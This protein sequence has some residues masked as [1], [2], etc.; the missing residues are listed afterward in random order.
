[1]DKNRITEL[2][3]QLKN[4]QK[5][6][7]EQYLA[8]PDTH[9]MLHG[10]SQ[11]VDTVLLALWADLNMPETA[12]LI[13]VGGYGRGE[14][15]P[16]SDVDLLI[17]LPTAADEALQGKIEQLVGM[18]WDIGLEVGHS[19]RTL[20]ECLD[21]ARSDITVQTA[22]LEARCLCGCEKLFDDFEAQLC[23]EIDGPSFYK[24]KKLE[25]QERYT[26]FNDTP[27]SLEPNSKESP[28]GLRDL[29]V[30]LWISQATGYGK[31]WK[32]LEKHGFITHDETL[33]IQRCERHLQHLRIR[34]HLLTKRREDRL[35]FDY[36]HSLAE[37]LK[38]EATKAR[39]ASEVLMQDYYK[40]A[41]LVTQLN[42]ILLQNMGAE[43]FPQRELSIRP[44]NKRFQA[45][46][47][48]LD[49]T[50][51][52][53]FESTP[54]AIL[55]SFW[56][57]Q[58]NP[59]LKGMTARTLR[60]LWRGRDLINA[61]FRKS[62]ENRAMFLRLFQSKRGLVHEFRRMNQYSI[63]G[64][65]IPA[66]GKIVG[67]MQHDL[68]HVYTV[69]QHILMVMRNL[70]RFSMEEFAHEY[71]LCSQLIN[72]LPRHWVLYIA[73]LFHDIAKGRG[74]DHSQLGMEDAREFCEHHQLNAEDTELVVWLVGSHLCM[75]AVAQKED[76]SDPDVI[77]HFAERVGSVRKLTALYLLTV[78]DIR[79]TSP[80]V[81][82]A[83]KGKLL[84]D[85]YHLALR[86]LE[87]SQNPD[88]ATSKEPTGVIQERQAEALRLLRFFALADAV[89]E[90]LWKQLDTVYFLRHS[91]DEIAWHTRA[92]HYRV[93]NPEPIVK[94]RLNAAGGVQVMVFTADQPDLFARLVGFFARAG[95]NIVDAKIH[96]TRHG[97]ALDSFELLD[98]NGEPC[99]REFIPFIEHE[100]AIA[101]KE[102][103]PVQQPADGRLSRE[104]KH[105]P[106]TPEVTLKA[107]E[108]GTRYLLSIVA[109]DR[110]G[111]LFKIACLLGEHH[112]HLHTAKIS[113]LGE[114]AED[115]FL[116]SGGKLDQS[117]ERQRIEN[118][119]MGQLQV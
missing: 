116:I 13:A 7:A 54:T 87:N 114:R 104:V 76:L 26:R 55:E 45:V 115:T 113:T 99:Q 60:A 94:A 119:L 117:S 16:A 71:P 102:Q 77:A 1:M 78:A 72:A 21:E 84:E 112:V 47:D 3:E 88:Q 46:H 92:L 41:K 107:D 39:R 111:L 64:R 97:Y 95:Y 9:K 17:L 79:G 42:T 50:S 83:W 100:L 118:E 24:A 6:L 43:I 108:R 59:E 63:L 10:R 57:M 51:E 20:D 48:L 58:Q 32:D 90:R 103:L 25:Q 33:Q 29:Q 27:Y 82:N 12:A 56:L 35:L 38:C 28:G 23:Q 101:L 8:K 44:L 4:G 96:T 61:E 70:R 53:L 67:Q 86:H 105:F 73:A 81:W 66:F 62:P 52:N 40:N 11:L 110:P 74:G 34:L 75:S 30:I 93:R 14:L 89:H 22:M 2:R 19:V 69:D 18:F 65:Y 5:K 37:Q 106:I 36:Q 80:K 68:F 15:Y 98:T 31:T 109:A 49:V 91:A 85:L